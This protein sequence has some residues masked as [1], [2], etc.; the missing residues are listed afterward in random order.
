MQRLAVPRGDERQLD[1]GLQ[2]AREFDLGLLGRFLETSR[3]G[4]VLPEVDTRL[5]LA[6]VDS[7]SLA[8]RAAHWIPDLVVFD[9][10]Q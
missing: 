5:L 6:L 9:G 3:G 8:R 4:A 1:V 7:Q 10:A 2:A